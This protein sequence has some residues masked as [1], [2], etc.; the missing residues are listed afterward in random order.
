MFAKCQSRHCALQKCGE[1]FRKSPR[2]D[3]RIDVR[4]DCPARALGVVCHRIHAPKKLDQ[5]SALDPRRKEVR[6]QGVSVLPARNP[7]ALFRRSVES[8][9]R[10]AERPF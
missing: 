7:T 6:I 10:L 8:P 5:G 9:K 4:F 1:A 2:T 3:F